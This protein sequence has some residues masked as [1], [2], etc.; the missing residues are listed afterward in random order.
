MVSGVA[1]WFP[2]VI[3]EMPLLLWNDRHEYATPFLLAI[4]YVARVSSFGSGF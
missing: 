2:R 4:H 1:G 3:V